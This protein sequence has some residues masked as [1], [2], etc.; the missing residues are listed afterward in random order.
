M[1]EYDCKYCFPNFWKIL[2]KLNERFF[3]KLRKTVKKGH[4]WP[5]MTFFLTTFD[6]VSGEKKDGEFLF[7]IHVILHKF[8]KKKILKNFIFIFYFL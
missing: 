5:K 2:E 6:Q 7:F 3:R 1:G 4:I 8:K